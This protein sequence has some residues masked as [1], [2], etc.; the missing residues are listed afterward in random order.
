MYDFDMIVG[1]ALIALG[2]GIY[3]GVYFGEN[4]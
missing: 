4:K 1:V 2:L 3:I